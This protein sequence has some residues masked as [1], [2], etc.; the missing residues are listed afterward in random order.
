MGRRGTGQDSEARRDWEE[1]GGVGGTVGGSEP[2]LGCQTDG[3]TPGP[4]TESD[5]VQR[6]LSSDKLLFI[7]R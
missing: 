3:Q 7:I 5:H 1:Q 6:S 2:L 4:G